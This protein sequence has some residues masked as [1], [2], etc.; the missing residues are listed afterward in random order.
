MSSAAVSQDLHANWVESLLHRHPKTRHL[1]IRVMWDEED[2]VLRL[3]GRVPS[4]RDRSRAEATAR[5]LDRMTPIRNCLT[6]YIDNENP[7]PS[8]FE[9]IGWTAP[10]CAAAA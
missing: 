1:S 4:P 3:E 6:V 2:S 10:A 8:W 9:R 7:S 5:E